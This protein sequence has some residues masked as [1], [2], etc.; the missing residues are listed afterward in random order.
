MDPVQAILILGKD[1]PAKE[2]A[3]LEVLKNPTRERLEA[4]ICAP[5]WEFRAIANI[6]I[7]TAK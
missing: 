5:E 7:D 6:L 3:W 4:V 1:H 2:K